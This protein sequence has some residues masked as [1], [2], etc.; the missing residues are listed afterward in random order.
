[1]SSSSSFAITGRDLIDLP[2]SWAPLI[3]I[4]LFVVTDLSLEKIY[5]EPE[6]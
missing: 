3:A 2:L 5:L 4:K 6:R 1:M